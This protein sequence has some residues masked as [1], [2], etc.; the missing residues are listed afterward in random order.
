[1]IT[2]K[3]EEERKVV[4]GSSGDVILAG[5]RRKEKRTPLA[6]SSSYA[7]S[8]AGAGAF[9]DTDDFTFLIQKGGSRFAKDH[10]G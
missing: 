7:Q 2:E 10:N 4:C 9:A 8:C 1:M 3:K 5:S 6:P